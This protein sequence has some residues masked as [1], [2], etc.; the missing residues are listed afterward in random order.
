MSRRHRLGPWALVLILAALPPTSAPASASVQLLPADTDIVFSLHVRQ[1]LDEPWLK[2]SAF[3]QEF[4]DE[5]RLAVRGDKGEIKK[6]FQSHGLKAR[7]ENEEKFLERAREIKQL[8]TAL[9]VFGLN[10]A[11]DIERVTVGFQVNEGAFVVVIEGTFRPAK[12]KAWAR[13]AAKKD[14]ASF[15]ITRAAGF[16]LWRQSDP[17]HPGV[18]NYIALLSPKIL[19]IASSKGMIAEVLGQAAGKQTGR[20]PRAMRTLLA[21]AENEHIAFAMKSSD[22]LFRAIEKALNEQPIP[23]E[24][25]IVRWVRDS[26][27]SWLR[28]FGKDIAV[29]SI[30]LSFRNDDFKYQIALDTRN[31]EVAK[32]LRQGIDWGNFWGGLFL[33]GAGGQTAR[34]LADVLAKKRVMVKGSAVYIDVQVPYTLI[35]KVLQGP[36]P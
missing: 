16:E 9:D 33:K 10:L 35:K 4:R 12:F 25:V 34:L 27:T 15:K 23:A 26:V 31:A 1:I 30:G 2:K 21:Q 20:L 22:V 18:A 24:E 13:D 28:K 3:A 14:P 29:M 11:R 36:W 32:A 19:V 7:G 5:W 6:Y 17:T 8:Q